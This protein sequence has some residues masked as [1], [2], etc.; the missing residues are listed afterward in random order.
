MPN[1]LSQPFAQDTSR[2][3][4]PTSEA[5]EKVRVYN[6][7][8]TRATGGPQADKPAEATDGKPAKKKGKKEERKECRACGKRVKKVYTADENSWMCREEHEGLC[9]ACWKRETCPVCPGGDMLSR[10][11][12]LTDPPPD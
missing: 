11:T 8:R 2:G 6:D 12:P 3:S 7:L 10:L 1:L 5:L 4:P 9:L